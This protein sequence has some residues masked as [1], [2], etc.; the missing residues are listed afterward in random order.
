[1]VEMVEMVEILKVITDTVK[2]LFTMVEI[3]KVLITD[4]VKILCTIVEMVENRNTK[5]SNYRYSKNAF[6]H[7][8]NG[9]DTKTCKMSNRRKFVT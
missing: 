9:R 2:I 7:G 8:R 3:L 5:S 1:M 6:Y 4:M